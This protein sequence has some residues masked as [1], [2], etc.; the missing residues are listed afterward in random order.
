MS[1]FTQKTVD[2]NIIL[3]DGTVFSDPSTCIFE[4][5]YWQS[6]QGLSGS[7]R[8]RGITYFF[9]HESKEYVLRHYLRGGLVGKVLDDQYFFSGVSKTR[10][11]RELHLL[12]QMRKLDLPVPRP[13]AAKIS[14]GFAYYRA[15]LIIERIPQARD[16]HQLLLHKPLDQGVW[17]NI[18][19]CIARFHQ[20]QVYHHD[21]NIH[22]IMLDAGQ[23]VWLID[24]DKCEFKP[25]DSWKEA[26]LHRLERSLEK[27]RSINQDY[28]YP[29]DTMQY[30][31]A[32]YHGKV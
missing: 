24:F 21:L 18:G 25:G 15:D 30:L 2:N 4:A 20:Q 32:G 5:D 14:Q 17:R 10:A 11:W 7:S 3:F 13:V 26:N 23:Q 16:V 31:R 12:A 22:N 8:G 27:E 6:Q 9:K 28:H 29:Q 19:A 1:D